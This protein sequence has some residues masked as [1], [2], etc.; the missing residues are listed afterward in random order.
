MPTTARGDNIFVTSEGNGTIGEYTT[1]GA[2][3][4]A[5]LISG[6]SNPAFFAVSGSNLF[7]TNTASGTIGEYT[8]SGATLN[9]SLIT[10]LD[11]PF[12]IAVSGSNLFVTNTASG[13][14]GEYTTS[15]ATVNASLITGLGLASPCLDRLCLSRTLPAV[16]LA[17]TPPR[18]RR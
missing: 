18:G 17:N 15:G 6:L 3:I 14:I 12:G 5:A 11:D 1:S 13:T 9:A 10:G 16:R 8:T 4:N 7:V 2:T